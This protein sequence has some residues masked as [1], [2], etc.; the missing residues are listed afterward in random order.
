MGIECRV[1]NLE[2]AVARRQ[3]QGNLVVFDL[4]EGGNRI[5]SIPAMNFR[6]F[7][8]E[9]YKMLNK[10]HPNGSFVVFK[11]ENELKD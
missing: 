3:G 2:K 9:G 5:V 1:K 11:G 4:E 7:A 6:G 8:E 10:L